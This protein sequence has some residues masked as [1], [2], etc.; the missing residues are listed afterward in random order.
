MGTISKEYQFGWFGACDGM[1]SCEPLSLETL[2]NDRSNIDSI[3]RVSHSGN[4]NGDVFEKF[5]PYNKDKTELTTA[6][7][8]SGKTFDHFFNNNFQSLE[9]GVGYIVSGR[10]SFADFDI[11]NF[12]IADETGFI[13]DE[14]SDVVCTET[15]LNVYNVSST[16]II[17]DQ[18]NGVVSTGW[19]LDGSV[20]LSAGDSTNAATPS[21][22]DVM[23][24]G[25]LIGHVT[26]TGTP[27]SDKI[28]LSV[29]TP[30][31]LEGKC[32]VG[33]ITNNLCQLEE[34]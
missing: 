7:T 30:G 3:I 2:G 23:H 34:K 28:Y 32:L 19:N 13:S 6:L 22:V 8:A 24:D 29:T 11:A 31:P 33:T 1:S 10:G 4:F 12:H 5:T 26:Y 20:S 25:Q 21:S 9:C 14:C 27:A 16:Q 18:A 15:G 17:S